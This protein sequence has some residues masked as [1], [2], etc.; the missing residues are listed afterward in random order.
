[1]SSKRYE[2]KLAAA[3]KQIGTSLA[4]H[5]RSTFTLSHAGSA[6]LE[7]F[8]LLRAAA[9]LSGLLAKPKP[10]PAEQYDMDENCAQVT[11]LPQRKTG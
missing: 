2:R 6:T 9:R 4:T 8:K 11:K 5:P 10:R 3:I 1:M 7:E